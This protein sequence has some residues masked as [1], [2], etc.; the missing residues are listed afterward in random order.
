MPQIEKETGVKIRFLAGLWRHS[1]PLFNSDM[2]ERLKVLQSPY[3]VGVD[4]MGHESNSS[5]ELESSIKKAVDL[6]KII[7]PDF[8]IRVHAGENPYFPENVRV[9]I[10]LGADRIGHALYADDAAISL[11]RERGTIFEINPDSNFALNNNDGAEQALLKKFISWGVKL[12]VGTDGHGLYGIDHKSLLNPLRSA[13]VEMQELKK[14]IQRDQ[15]YILKM[16]K[17]FASRT[18]LLEV[19]V[20]RNLPRGEYTPEYEKQQHARVKK[21]KIELIRVCPHLIASSL[22]HKKVQT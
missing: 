2:I 12:T 5:W 16:E 6:K 8:Q 10:E 4:F 1:D 9:A 15:E 21:E 22:S 7:S 13:G 17:L 20:Q 19:P 11:A 18:H 14:M 3:I